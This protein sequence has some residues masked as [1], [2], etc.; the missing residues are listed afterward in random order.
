MQLRYMVERY[1]D[2]LQCVNIPLFVLIKHTG[3]SSRWA[4]Q[5]FSE[6]RY[7][8]APFGD[9]WIHI[10]R[11]TRMLPMMGLHPI[12][13]N[14]SPWKRHSFVFSKHSTWT[15]NHQPT[16]LNLIRDTEG[17]NQCL[18]K[19]IPR[20]PGVTRQHASSSAKWS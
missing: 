19:L 16:I 8:D 20:N 14:N 1:F 2:V 12:F 17:L 18:S 11:L 10:A 5:V 9:I 3:G 7:W 13:S 15:K 4:P 6:P